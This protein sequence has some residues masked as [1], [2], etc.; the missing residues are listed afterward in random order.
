MQRR[1][2]AMPTGGTEER[3]ELGGGPCPW[4]SAR[5]GVRSRSL[6]AQ[7]DVG[8]RE[9]LLGGLSE[10]ATHDEMDF[11]DGLGG[12][13]VAVL[14]AACGECGVEVVEVFGA[15]RLECVQADGRGDVAFDH[16][17]VAV[18]GGGTNSTLPF[19]QPRV[20]QVVAE[21]DSVTCTQDRHTVGLGDARRHR[22]CVSERTP[23]RMPSPPF[24]TGGRIDA[25][26]RDDMEAIVSF[27][28]VSHGEVIGMTTSEPTR[29][30]T[31][32]AR[33]ATSGIRLTLPP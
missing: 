7:R 33:R 15:D 20:R 31:I 3:A 1:V 22:F 16:P 29:R 21:G 9:S 26:I 5:A 32:Y 30:S 27:N 8:A 18:G 25:V 28:D 13:P 11:V 23:S 14:A 12:E 6:G 24:A 2:Q 19:G 4:P 10:S 17:P